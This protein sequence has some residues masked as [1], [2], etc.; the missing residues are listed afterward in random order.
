M[1]LTRFL[2]Q[3]L[4]IPLGGN[5]KGK[6]RTYA[7][8]MIVFSLS[9]LWHGADWTFI[10]WGI[11]HGTLQVLCRIGKNAIAK[12]PGWLQWTMTF[13]LINIAWVFFRADYTRQ[14][15]LLF[16]RLLAGGGGW[17]QDV[18]LTEACDA[19]LA[20]VLLEKLITPGTAE[21][22]RQFWTAA[23]FLF[24]TWVCVKM[25][26]T[27]EIVEKKNRSGRYFMVLGLVFVWAF[28]CLSQVSKFIYFNF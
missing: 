25:P 18:L 4:Y 22:M 27:H 15:L 20:V 9:G 23:V 17:C 26:S 21:I 5:R 12:I 13:A 16:G 10:I 24:W 6:W 11:M 2:T 3:Y 14:P 1:T 7:N 8:I 28:L 19:T